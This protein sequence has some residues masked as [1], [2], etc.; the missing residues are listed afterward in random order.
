MGAVSHCSSLACRWDGCNGAVRKLQGLFIL[1]SIP[2]AG[3]P[4]SHH[5]RFPSFP[6]SVIPAEAGI[7][8][9]LPPGVCHMLGRSG[10]PLP[11]PD[12]G[13]GMTGAMPANPETGT[14]PA[15]PENEKALW[16]TDGANRALGGLGFPRSERSVRW[17]ELARKNKPRGR[18]AGFSRRSQYPRRNW[19]PEANRAPGGPG[20]LKPN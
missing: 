12:R 14:M 20:L 6:P 4:A 15:N 19:E 5:S 18:G 3:D 10:F 1:P 9:A 16:E 8:T 11:D 13:A 17:E 2:P 7:H